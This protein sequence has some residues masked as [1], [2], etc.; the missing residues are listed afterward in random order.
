[1]LAVF[2]QA[3]GLWGVTQ[4][5][6]STGDYVTDESGVT[7]GAATEVGKLVR[8]WKLPGDAAFGDEQAYTAPVTATQDG[9]E[10]V[11]RQKASAG[12][13]GFGALY[14][15][16]SLYRPNPTNIIGEFDFRTGHHGWGPVEF[17]NRWSNEYGG[18]YEPNGGINVAGFYPTDNV[19]EGKN[20]TIRSPQFPTTAIHSI[21]VIFDQLDG[22]G[23]Y[24]QV[25]GKPSNS[26]AWEI[27][28]PT[29]EVHS[30]DTHYPY[31]LPVAKNCIYLA[32]T[33]SNYQ[34]SSTTWRFFK[35]IVA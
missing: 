2:E 28:T 3:K 35:V 4:R 15:V 7:I 9:V 24:M 34:H 19:Y 25:W 1:V 12:F 26:G 33:M 17:D 22:N 23:A 21:D 14:V 5:P 8:L 6:F 27:I 32:V 13:I 20:S 29:V 18:I 31:L 11:Y 16:P 30:T 10:V